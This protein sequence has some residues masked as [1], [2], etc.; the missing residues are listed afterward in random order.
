MVEGLAALQETG[1]P[2]RS[3]G[4]GQRI[5]SREDL[6][7]GEQVEGGQRSGDSGFGDGAHDALTVTRAT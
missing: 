3:D 4:T 7:L 5:A 2:T 6:D 1:Q